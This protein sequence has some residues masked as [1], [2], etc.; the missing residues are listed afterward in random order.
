VDEL[1]PVVAMPAALMLTDV[2]VKRHWDMA[3]AIE[4]VEAAIRAR[5]SKDLVAPPRH[6]VSFGPTT[7]LVFAIGGM[8]PHTGDAVGARSYFSRSGVHFQDQVVSVW[9]PKTGALKGVIVGSALGVLRMGAIGGVAIRALSHPSAD[10]VGVIGTGKQAR[11]HLEAAAAVR[12]LKRAQVFG[13]S[14]ESA[15]TF[16]AEM[17]RRLQLDVVAM[18]TARAAV[19]GA[20]LVI[21]ATTSLRPVIS[22][23]DLDRGAFVHTVGYKS[24]AAKELDLDIAEAA[25][26]LIT[27]SLAQVAA[28]GKTFILHGTPYLG[29]MID[30]A[31][32]LS[33]RVDVREPSSDAIRVCYP[34][35]LTG[36]DTVVADNILRSFAASQ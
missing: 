34:V 16:A 18:P 8:T 28:F 24:P 5:A 17:A 13:R 10:T 2:D 11:S 31:D 3:A 23:A 20:S 12:P 29:R 15:K 32:V 21:V 33:G 19:S 9:S 6:R 7:E 4:Q 35:G 14:E 30:L 26:W 22:A 36:I 27:D 25:D 1:E